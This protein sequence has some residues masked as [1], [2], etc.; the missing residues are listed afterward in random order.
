MCV[1]ATPSKLQIPGSETLSPVILQPPQ[2]SVTPRRA[3]KG[4][5]NMP[6][7]HIGFRTGSEGSKTASSYNAI[8]PAHPATSAVCIRCTAIKRPGSLSTT[9]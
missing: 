2:E 8:D 7:L 6:C 3:M 9:V 1:K 4:I 5:T